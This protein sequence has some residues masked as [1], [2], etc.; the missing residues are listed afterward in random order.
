[1][2]GPAHRLD[3]V[4]IV[5]QHQFPEDDGPLKHPI[6]PA[7][8]EK[9][10]NFYTATVYDKGA[11][12][13]RMYETILSTEG[14]KKGL[15]LYLKKHDGSAATCD[16]FLNAMVEANPGKDDLE[17]FK[18]WYSVG[19]T[20]EVKVDGKIIENGGKKQYQLT[21][22]QAHTDKFTEVMHI[23]IAYG[24]LNGESGDEIAK[25]QVYHLKEK[26]G[27]V[28][29]DIDATISKAVPSLNRNF[30]AP[31]KLVADFYTPE[32]LAC[33]AAFDTD[34]VAAFEASQKLKLDLIHE[35][36]ENM[37]AVPKA[38]EVLKSSTAAILSENYKKLDIEA[39][40]TLG[41]P[42]VNDLINNYKN[43][44]VDPNQ[45]AKARSLIKKK[46]AAELKQDLESRLDR[47][48]VAKEFEINQ[49]AI[50]QRRLKNIVL[51]MLIANNDETSVSKANSAYETA[52]TMTERLGA[53]K[54]LISSNKD[55]EVCAKFY[56]RAKKHPLVMDKWFAAQASNTSDF[57]RIV[58]LSKHEDF[59]YD[60]PNRFRSLV[61]RFAAL[62]TDLFHTAEGYKFVAE[63]IT[64]C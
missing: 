6:R 64:R 11:E 21:F 59:K 8:Y 29:I 23:P 36:Y 19:G 3:Q 26:T 25:T 39:A 37:D 55:T 32:D 10:D 40:A 20:P 50:G 5:R 9:I 53:F 13:I 18:K 28:N 1:M 12:V 30:S 42:S 58:D 24:L 52:L 49:A 16:D 33:L 44:K 38:Y 60:N 46:L 63:N 27:T 17:L 43:G 45:M 51:D 22:E 54:P 47:I 48:P 7:S 34:L 41:L 56:E 15:T 14:F 57:K 2:C 61:L 35:Q 4:E 62:N 31:I